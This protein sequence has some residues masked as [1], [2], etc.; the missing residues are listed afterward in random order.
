MYLGDGVFR[1]ERPQA[2]PFTYDDDNMKK[3]KM[4]RDELTKSH[5]AIKEDSLPRYS[6]TN[7]VTY[8]QFNVGPVN[9]VENLSQI[10]T[11]SLGC[12]KNKGISSYDKDY[13]PI[14]M[15]P[16]GLVNENYNSNIY[17]NN[18]DSP[19]KLTSEFRDNYKSV[20]DEVLRSYKRYDKLHCSGDHPPNCFADQSPEMLNNFESEANSNYGNYDIKKSNDPVAGCV[21]ISPAPFKLTDGEPEKNL[22]NTLYSDSFVPFQKICLMKMLIRQIKTK[23]LETWKQHVGVFIQEKKKIQKTCGKQQMTLLMILQ[24][25]MGKLQQLEKLKIP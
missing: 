19:T 20:P 18:Q 5:F 13:Q 24:K 12:G 17:L 16:N 14:N 10:T 25:S 7:D 23:R 9:H 22:P 11:L 3:N 2:V 8:K 4:I 21:T 15:G 1:D 6:T